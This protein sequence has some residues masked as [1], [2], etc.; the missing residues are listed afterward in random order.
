MVLACKQLILEIQNCPVLGMK[1]GSFAL[2]NIF[3]S[4]VNA[5]GYKVMN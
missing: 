2:T 5:N 3:F 1:Q 4:L